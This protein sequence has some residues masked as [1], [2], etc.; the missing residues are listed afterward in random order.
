LNLNQK[1]ELQLLLSTYIFNVEADSDEKAVQDFVAA[2]TDEKRRSLMAQIEEILSGGGL[3]LEELGAQ[4]NRW[5]GTE[6]EASHWLRELLAFLGKSKGGDAAVVKDSNGTI[7]QEGD[8][9]LVIK[10]LKVKGGSSDLKR[11][12]LVKNIHLVDDPEVIECRVSGST[13]VLKTCFLKKA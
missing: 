13:L 1:P 4:S 5:F 12:T 2:T 10:D 11:G 8:S 6:A 9:V 7:L 3:S